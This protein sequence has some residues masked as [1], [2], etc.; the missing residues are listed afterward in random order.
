MAVG[1]TPTLKK[2]EPISDESDDATA[3]SE[4]EQEEEWEKEEASKGKNAQGDDDSEIGEEDEDLEDEEDDKEKEEERDDSD[5]P[6]AHQPPS[7]AESD[8]ESEKS[9]VES[10]AEVAFESE[11]SEVEV[12]EGSRLWEREKEI[13]LQDMEDSEQKSFK[14][15]LRQQAA[16][17]A[18]QKEKANQDKGK[19]KKG[20]QLLRSKLE[21]SSSSDSDIGNGVRSSP[22]APHAVF[23]FDACSHGSSSS[24]SF[25][26]AGEGRRVLGDRRGGLGQ[27]RRRLGVRPPGAQAVALELAQ[28]NPLVR[29]PAPDG[30]WRVPRDPRRLR[31][32][33]PTH[34]HRL[35]G[36]FLYKMKTPC[37]LRHM[38]IFS[39]RALGE[40]A[41]LD[42]LR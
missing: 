37:A 2:A 6:K 31:L 20:S 3:F 33:P 36:I 38:T 16:A 35:G 10:E 8:S 27:H 28:P 12:E 17:A 5:T 4:G 9:E 18:Q 39:L 26:A 30:L 40:L 13:T 1:R 14:E 23:M 32:S 21:S 34:R 7:D 22:R 19:A 25:C 24:S 15:S 42:H 41:R 29:H 11:Q